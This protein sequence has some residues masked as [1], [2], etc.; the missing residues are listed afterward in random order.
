MEVDMKPRLMERNRIAQAVH[1]AVQAY[2]G[3]DGFQF[4]RLYSVTGWL[5]L[6]SLGYDRTVMQSGR[7]VL[8]PDPDSADGFAMDPEYGIPGEIHSWLALPDPCHL[9]S[10]EDEEG[11]DT[12]QFE[13]PK[14]TPIAVQTKPTAPSVE[15]DMFCEPEFAAELDNLKSESPY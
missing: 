3:T 9:G 8:A 15:E 10:E 2:T 1:N 7:L 13:K 14:E 11:F 4:C 12:P 6:A 5:L